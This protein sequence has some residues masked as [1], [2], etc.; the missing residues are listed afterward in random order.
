MY[1]IRTPP[2]DPSQSWAVGG[3]EDIFARLKEYVD[4]GVYKF[5]LR[6]L[7]D[8]DAELMAQTRRLA[9]EVI[10]EAIRLEPAD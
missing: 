4:A 1:A 2:R 8:G 5:I 9:E 7:G 6:P 3:A 10:P